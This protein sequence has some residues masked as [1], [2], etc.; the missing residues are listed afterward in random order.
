MVRW[1]GKKEEACD[2]DQQ[3]AVADI[4]QQQEESH[5]TF[6]AAQVLALEIQ[7]HGPHIQEAWLEHD[8]CINVRNHFRYYAQKCNSRKAT[9][10][11]TI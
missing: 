5:T 2:D 11:N 8:V 4:I 10:I 1:Y 7:S 6:G 3:M 9:I